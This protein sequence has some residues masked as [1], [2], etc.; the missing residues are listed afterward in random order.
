MEIK[1][2]DSL[3]TPYLKPNTKVIKHKSKPLTAP[4]E[5]YGS[6]IQAVDVT[7]QEPNHSSRELHLVAKCRPA[8]E[9]LCD[10]FNIQI[11][12]KKE[13]DMYLKVIPALTK[14]EEEYNA[15][16]N[17]SELFAKC[18]GARINLKPGS[19][20]IDED[21]VILL[22]NLK[23]EGFDVGNR[24]M[25]FNEEHV[26]RILEDLA[27]FHAVPV[28]FKLKKTKEFE[29]D[30]LPVL[31]GVKMGDV[32]DDKAKSMS[33]NDILKT[34][35]GSDECEP[36]VD[37]L[38]QLIIATLNNEHR[39]N[40]KI[41]IF[42]TVSHTDY[43]VNNTMILKNDKGKPVKNKIVDLQLISYCSATRDLL[44]FLYS[45]VEPS[46][47]YKNIDKF[48]KFYYDAFISCLKKFK[49]ELTSF[50]WENF[51]AEL[52]DNAPDELGHIL[53]MYKPILTKRGAIDDM[54]NLDMNSMM[55]IDVS[56][57][58]STRVRDCIL[59]FI[60]RKWI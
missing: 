2:I 24:L 41:G 7:I 28:A 1:K 18:Y 37:K 10:I 15:N 53:F 27:T 47:M 48:L 58:Y 19:D 9:V 26:Y 8:N 57:D 5:N 6:V 30:F 50:S 51:N 17:I 25:G 52:K 55:N 14:F 32:F 21:A 22:E 40:P 46:V 13:M 42:A 54:S 33:V 35:K 44:F 31:K 20:I 3:L 43:W 11:T 59:S 29:T 39:L 34:I 38:S 36:Y 4:G 16:C 12:F 45:S 56:S 60:K 23:V 49:V